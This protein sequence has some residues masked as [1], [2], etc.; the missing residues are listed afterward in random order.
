M[1]SR[2]LRSRFPVRGCSLLIAATLVSCG[3]GSQ[4]PIPIDDTWIGAPAPDEIPGAPPSLSIAPESTSDGWV[5]STP[6]AEGIDPA[7]LEGILRSIR[8]GGYPRVDSMIVARHGRLVAEGYFNGYAPDTLHDLRSTGK[9]FTSALTGI[10]ADRGLLIVDDPISLYLRDFESSKNLDGRKRAITLRHLLDMS[11]GLDCDDSNPASPGNEEKMYPARNWVKF[12]LDLPMAADP[13]ARSSYCTGGVIVLGSL[14]SSRAG[15]GLDDFAAT[16]LFGPLDIRSAHWRRSPDG[17]ATGG[18]GLKLRPRDVAKLG[19]LY[20][21][22]GL[23][24]GRRVLSAAWVAESRR[25]TARI[26]ADGYGYLWW[27]RGFARDGVVA[28]SYFTSGN[29]GNFVFVFP[30]LDLVVAFT[31]SNYDSRAMDQPFQ[32]LTER[33]LPIV[34]QGG[35]GLA[36]DPAVRSPTTS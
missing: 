20:R 10:A 7:G 16:W 26:G 14:L 23:W 19:E 5:T 21:A 13:G 30:S 25:S 8:D 15:V 17:Q 22:D 34:L 9:S 27:K 29:G 2:E 18:G 24:N 28:D 11:S 6:A 3:G 4:P 1:S 32:I 36:A 31:G 35:A 33:L 12:V